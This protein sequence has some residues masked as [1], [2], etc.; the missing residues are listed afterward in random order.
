[1]KGVTK[2]D[3]WDRYLEI[4]D[5]ELQHQQSIGGMQNFITLCISSFMREVSPKKLH[6]NIVMLYRSDFDELIRASHKTNVAPRNPK[7]T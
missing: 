7:T 6:D 2:I 4:S 3:G 1:M 5:Q